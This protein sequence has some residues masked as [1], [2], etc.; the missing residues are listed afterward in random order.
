MDLPVVIQSIIGIGRWP[1]LV[2]LVIGGLIM[3]Y[4]VAPHRATPKFSW[5]NYGAIICG[6]LWVLAS[7]LF[8]YYVSN[9]GSYDKAYGS[10]AAVIIL[11]FW[12]FISAF[13]LLLGAEINSEME[14]QTKV[15]TTTGK[16]KPLGERGAYHADHVAP[17]E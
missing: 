2:V 1:V 13:I 9:F 5:V 3:V 7:V 11:Q 15:D 8:S 16:E 10:F 12:L 4:R 17:L 6:I 14:H